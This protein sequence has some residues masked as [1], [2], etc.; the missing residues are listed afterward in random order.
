LLTVGQSNRAGAGPTGLLVSTNTHAV[1]VKQ[2]KGAIISS[3]DTHLARC[4]PMQPRR[5]AAHAGTVVCTT[6]A[7]AAAVLDNLLIIN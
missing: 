5:G 7:D 4:R 1:K 6:T 3:W 2:V